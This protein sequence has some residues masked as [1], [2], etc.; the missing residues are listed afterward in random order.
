MIPR[1]HR[2]KEENSHVATA[3]P[4]VKLTYDDYCAAPA[5]NRYE[6]LDGELIMVPAPNLKH[7]RVNRE[8]STRLDRFIK[9]QALGELLYAPCDVLLSANDIVQPDLLFVSRERE[10]LLTGGK[11]VQGAPDLAVEILSPSSA[12]QDRGKKRELYGKHGV[13][14]YWLVDPVAE[15][16][17]INRLQ[18]EVLLP[19]RT[20]GRGETVRSPLL[21]GL[22]LD[23]NDV[24]PS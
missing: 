8:L 6:L 20:F 10:H 9:D 21:A 23:L 13:T 24:F 11:N 15:T 17:Q 4:A 7:Q 19:T 2:G 14:E 22:E 5:D 12:E 1:D 18:G 3:Q 16:I